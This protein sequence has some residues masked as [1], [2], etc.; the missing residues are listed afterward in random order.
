MVAIFVLMP[1]SLFAAP[2]LRSGE[3]VAVGETQEVADDFYAAG[4]TVT[5]SGKV[6][7]DL[8]AAGGTIMINGDV[9]D[10]VAVASG[11]ARIGGGIGGDARV[12]GGEVTIDGVVDGDVLVLGGIVRVLSTARIGGDRLFYGGEVTIDGDVRGSLSG[13][14]EA[15]RLN[16]PVRGDVAVRASRGLSLGEQA[17]I[18]GALSYESTAEL[19]R[20]SGAVVRGE[21]TR[22]EAAPAAGSLSAHLLW[23]LAFLFTTTAAYLLLPQARL[24]CFMRRSADAFLWNALIGFCVFAAAPV[25]AGVLFATLI[26]LPLGALLLS[27]YAFLLLAACALSGIFAGALLARHF[28]GDIAI[29]LK[30]SLIGAGALALALYI[31]YLGLTAIA[32]LALALLGGMT[33]ALYEWGKTRSDE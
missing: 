4:G 7:G 28:D 33:T 1:L 2:V 29:T 18:D 20:A 22:Q 11:S 24:L 8:Y 26:G 17:H 6:A 31:P 16:G 13:R 23:L 30:W 14:A 32:T 19:S 12:V 15:V 3:E 27:F 9:A 25:A 5:V 10:D 21:V